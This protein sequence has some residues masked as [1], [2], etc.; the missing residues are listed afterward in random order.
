MSSHVCSLQVFNQTSIERLRMKSK[1]LTGYLEYLI[2]TNF[3]KVSK[4]AVKRTSHDFL[5]RKTHESFL[6][7]RKDKKK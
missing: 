6:E 1:A 3:S 5:V 4:L 2:K 7:T